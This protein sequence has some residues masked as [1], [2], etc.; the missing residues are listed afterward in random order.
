M[1]QINRDF[2]LNISR[3]LS[4]NMTASIIMFISMP[5]ISRLYSPVDFGQASYFFS[6]VTV[7]AAVS[8]L[9]YD[10]CIV[11]ADNQ[12]M[13]HIMVINSTLICLGISLFFGA[14]TFLLQI[15]DSPF[16]TP[17]ANILY[18]LPIII[19]LTGFIQILFSLLSRDKNFGAI[20]ILNVSKTAVQ[21][22]Y[23]VLSALLGAASG[24]SLVIAVAIGQVT[25]LLPFLKQL[26]NIVSKLLSDRI[27]TR[28]LIFGLKRYK[29]FLFF[30]TWSYMFNLLAMQLPVLFIGNFFNV[31]EAGFYAM[32]A[33]LLSFP[34]L[35]TNAINRVLYQRAAETEKYGDLQGFI[36]EVYRRLVLY[37]GIPFFLILIYGRP[38]LG[39]IFGPQWEPSGSFSQMLAPLFWIVFCTSP[40]GSLYNIQERQ[41]EHLIFVTC[42]LVLQFG[43][44]TIGFI[45]SDI[46]ISLI[47]YVVGGLLFRCASVFWIMAKIGIHINDSFGWMLKS[48]FFSLTPLLFWKVSRSYIE[49]PVFIDIVAVGSIV[50][51]FYLIAIRHDSQLMDS[52]RNFLSPAFYRK[53]QK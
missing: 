40:F 6:I 43:G 30:S 24:Y 41:K 19:F 1:R 29:N 35:L 10:A 53:Y 22:G 3:L 32:A 28:D 37:S 17:I 42:R 44:M 8:S 11:I 46:R 34:Q 7:V 25:S 38:L 31:K 33:M 27:T 48:I 9:R 23:R 47:L 52:L 14:L 18:L 21:Q 15:Y 39:F 45:L 36:H 12:K 20:A 51:L 5:L 2:I 26:K 4:G 16:F 50:S 49:V 13:A